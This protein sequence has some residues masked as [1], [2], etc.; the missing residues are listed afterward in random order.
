MGK[1]KTVNYV[2]IEV[3]SSGLFATQVLSVI[4]HTASS[5]D[6]KV[7]LC[8]LS[9]PWHMWTLRREMKEL[10]R[11]C[12]NFGCELVL[13]P[14][15]VPVKFSMRNLALMWL[16]RKWL[17]LLME[18]LPSADLWHCRGYLVTDAVLQRRGARSVVFDMRSLWVDEHI[19]TKTLKLG[20]K[21]VCRW[22]EVE[23]DCVAR[24]SYVLGVSEP[25]ARIGGRF[26]GNS[27][28]TVPIAVD[29][30]SCAFDGDAR[31]EL[32]RSLGWSR[33]VV[34]VYSGS[35]GLSGLNEN[36]LR[37]MLCEI[38]NQVSTARLLLL[39]SEPPARVRELMAKV[40][41][42][43]GKWVH[44]EVAT[45]QIGRYLSA[46]DFGI[47]ALSPQ[48]DADSRLGTKVVEYWANQLP[49]VVTSTVGAAAKIIRDHGLGLVVQVDGEGS[50][51][52][53]PTQIPSREILRNAFAAFDMSD[54]SSV[55][56][57]ARH[58]EIYKACMNMAKQSI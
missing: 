37:A 6:F 2:T 54:F 55:G 39:S 21:M 25:M 14:C 36:A 42:A 34:G 58:I 19:A 49:A 11:R 31:E 18:L 23:R 52:S 3:I 15:L 10:S 9:Y 4:K 57:S 38:F 45:D 33:S 16:I 35:F 40:N 44:F 12:L 41:N 7:R 56:V 1:K 22:R 13:I 8:V 5:A 51:V 20:S 32:R 24:S 30:E 43:D 28:Q 46:G 27:Y 53:W 26:S 50:Q 17:R 47:H 29:L 48:P